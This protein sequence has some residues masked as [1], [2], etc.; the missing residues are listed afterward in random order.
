MQAMLVREAAYHRPSD[1]R[2]R[3]SMP[4]QARNMFNARL[5]GL[6]RTLQKLPG[7]LRTGLRL[8]GQPR[9]HE[10][11]VIAALISYLVSGEFRKVTLAHVEVCSG[12]LGEWKRNRKLWV[13]LSL[14]QLP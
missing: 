14:N 6:T 9:Q 7:I 1:G 12:R 10:H 5:L 13:Q 11:T 8:S 4:R 2:L 3:Q